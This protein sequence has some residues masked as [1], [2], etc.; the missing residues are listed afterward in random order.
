ME[1]GH[2]RKMEI[3][4]ANIRIQLQDEEGKEGLIMNILDTDQISEGIFT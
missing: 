3:H 1:Y 2:G 4:Q